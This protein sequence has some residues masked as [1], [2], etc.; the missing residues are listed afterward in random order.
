MNICIVKILKWNSRGSGLQ[1]GLKSKIIK[2][3]KFYG[4]AQGLPFGLGQYVKRP[5]NVPTDG[6]D[7][8]GRYL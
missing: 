2:F 7:E 4:F 1:D 3:T 5:I 8:L 6:T